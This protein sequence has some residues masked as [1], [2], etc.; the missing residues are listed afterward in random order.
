MLATHDEMTATWNL[1]RKARFLSGVLAGVSCGIRVFLSGFL[2]GQ[3]LP[4]P[5]RGTFISAL[6]VGNI[7]SEFLPFFSRWFV[8]FSCGTLVR[9][10]CEISCGNVC[11]QI[12]SVAGCLGA[13]R[14][15]GG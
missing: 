9:F 6:E 10:S 12:P 7:P 14:G 11:G 2:R 5:F 13:L 4:N 15:V 8:L 1:A 3:F